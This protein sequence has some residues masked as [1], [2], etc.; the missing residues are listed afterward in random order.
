LNGGDL[1]QWLDSIPGNIFAL[2]AGDATKAAEAGEVRTKIVQTVFNDGLLVS[3]GKKLLVR[4]AA[5]Y[6]RVDTFEDLSLPPLSSIEIYGV[7]NR[8]KGDLVQEGSSS[9]ELV[10]KCLAL[11]SQTDERLMETARRLAAGTHSPAE[12]VQRTLNYLQAQCHYSLKVGKFHSQQPVAEFLFE[13][14]QG[15]CE[16]FASAA[17]V[18]LR[19]EGVP[20]R[21][22]TGFNIQEGNRQGSHYVVR[23]ADAHAWVEAYMP[24][25]GWMQVDPT[26]EAEYEALHTNLKSGLWATSEEW[27]AAELAEVSARFGQGDWLVTSHWIWEQVKTFL[28]SVWVAER[29][30]RLLL[31]ALVL[32][33]TVLLAR[34]RRSS[35]AG[36][37]PQV[38]PQECDSAPQELVELMRRLDNIWAREGFIRPASRAPLEHLGGIP[39]GK[40]SPSLRD[41]SRRVIEC[42]Y[43]TSFGGVPFVPAESRDLMRSLEQVEASR[44]T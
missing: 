25:D 21:Y 5:P 4:L 11:P 3:P 28:R 38:S 9:A 27:L 22:V 31:F 6:L 32:V 26:P 24:N 14:K 12:R 7:V 2:S 36:R 42:F 41:F 23:E 17:A 18:L 15:Y 35:S 34:W 37:A 20:S 8:P 30:F 44:S 43:R 39:V 33:M 16:Y 1:T 13:K 40:I 29:P 19:L 10:A